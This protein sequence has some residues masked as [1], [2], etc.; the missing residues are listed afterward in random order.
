MYCNKENINILTSVLVGHGVRHIVVC[1]GSRNAAIVHNFNECPSFVCHPVTDE[2][3]AGFIALGIREESGSP[4]AVCVTSGSALLNLLPAVAE[5]TY[6]HLGI[7]VISADR[8][9]AWIGQ[10]D[11]QTLPQENVF[12]SF[13]AISTCISEPQNDTERWECNRCVNEAL[14][15]NE[16]PSHPSVHINVPISEPLFEFSISELPDERIIKRV[17]DTLPSEIKSAKKLMLVCGQ[18]SKPLDFSKISGQIAILSEVLTSDGPNLTDQMLA[19]LK[20]IPEDMVPDCIIYIGGNTVSKRLRHFLRNQCSGASHITVSEDGSLHDIS[21]RTSI[22]FEGTPEDMVRRLEDVGLMDF[23]GRWND[24]RDK[25][26]EK[27]LSFVPGYSQMLAVKLFEETI[28]D[29][30]KVYY[31]NSM[32]VRLGAIYARH[33]CHCNRGLNGIDGSLS[34]AAGASLA[35]YDKVFCVAGD[36]SF[37]YDENALWQQQLG[38]NFRILLLNN[39]GGTIFKTLP[40][41]SESPS[42]RVLAAGE[43]NYNAEGICKQ[44]GIKYLRATDEKSLKEGIPEFFNCESSRPVVFEVLTDSESDNNIYKQYYERMEE[45]AGVQGDTPGRI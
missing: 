43:H 13:A 27:H 24:F 22:V 37:F 30:A 41:L 16:R 29:A 32:S 14:L 35:T 40:G 25:V 44:F 39:G 6:R 10:M 12:G 3:S 5:A 19:A 11:G 4:V 8:P 36:L 18:L 7:I 17:K 38:G 23:A 15:E 33:F 20:E 26:K 28:G 1:P 42:S 21:C 34:T 31:A 9:R 45:D 2:R